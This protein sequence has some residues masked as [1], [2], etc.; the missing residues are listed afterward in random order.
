MSVAAATPAANS[1]AA[2]A[3]TASEVTMRA[4]LPTA[5]AA[6]PSSPASASLCTMLQPGGSGWPAIACLI[7]TKSATICTSALI[8]R[9]SETS[10]ITGPMGMLR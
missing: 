10:A 9:N 2:T 7:A 3:R 5:T 4:R 1:T 8:A 6:L